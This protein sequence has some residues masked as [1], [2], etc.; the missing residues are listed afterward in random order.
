VAS[1]KAAPGSDATAPV[2]KDRRGV[3]VVSARGLERTAWSR[4]M[5]PLSIGAPPGGDAQRVDQQR[6]G[7]VERGV[8]NV[9]WVERE[10][11]DVVK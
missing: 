8:G 5:R 3:R 6:R 10:G 11:G 9:E 7:G 4:A 1:A 2:E